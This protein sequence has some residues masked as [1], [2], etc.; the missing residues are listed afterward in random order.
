[1]FSNFNKI[2]KISSLLSK[3]FAEDFLKLLVQY[4][5]ISASEAASRL[6]LHI[7]TA[8]D[9]MESLYELKIIDRVE[10]YE[11]K[12]PYFRFFLVHKKIEMSLDLNDLV[13]NINNIDE[14]TKIREKK[15]NSA[16]F[17]TSGSNIYISSISIF[18]GEGRSKKE[19][20]I[21]LTKSQGLFLY[22]LPFPTADKKSLKDILS[23]S[24]VE[25]EY[26]SE[27]ISIVSFLLE[28]EIIEN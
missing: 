7:K 2:S 9:F 11:K 17:S 6:N 13:K 8:Q 27:I 26:L 28:N 3:L 22:H 14:N 4:K 25:D 16:I 15:G 10:V 5:D 20:K 23:I 12:R 21:S 18:K 1:M 19:R 24:K